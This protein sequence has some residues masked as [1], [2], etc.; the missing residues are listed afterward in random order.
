[1]ARSSHFTAEQQLKSASGFTLIELLITIAL[2]SILLAIAVPSFN[3]FVVNSRL[4]AQTNSIV[5]AINFTRSEAI[6]RN[7]SI[8]LCRASSDTA[9]S[10]E[11]T[12]GTW[13]YW[14]VR[15]PA[16]NVVRRGSINTYGNTIVVR[17]TLTSDEA[18]F[19]SEGRVLTGGALVNNQ[20]ISVCT[21]SQSENNIRQIVLGSASRITLK[22]E[23]GGC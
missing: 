14:I 7:T 1:M 6:K 22:T 4:V 18:T 5:A 11:T 21:T 20:Q 16:A 23:D 12:A 19:S 2:A 17:S 9:T 8:S 3:N 13:Q 15:T 10:C